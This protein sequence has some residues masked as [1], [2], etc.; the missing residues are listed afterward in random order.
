MI[1]TDFQDEEDWSASEQLAEKFREQFLGGDF[2]PFDCGVYVRWF[3]RDSLNTMAL[4]ECY[5]YWHA[6][7]FL[8]ELLRQLLAGCTN[9][10][11]R[12]VILDGHFYLIRSKGRWRDRCG[13]PV[14]VE[15]CALL[16][17]AVRQVA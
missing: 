5:S 6:E 1:P 10:N 11:E 17:V 16:P 8:P 13:E 9:D 12:E 2:T 3:S 14:I 15:A 4:G 7:I